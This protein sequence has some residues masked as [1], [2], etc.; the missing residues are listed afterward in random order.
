MA[1]DKN[2][3]IVTDD[4]GNKAVSV[5]AVPGAVKEALDE[6]FKKA[7]LDGNGTITGTE[8]IATLFS[9]GTPLLGAAK[10]LDLL[11]NE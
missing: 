2:T 10:S 9:V 3:L 4:K 8:L 11:R 6:A 5:P 7:D 1:D